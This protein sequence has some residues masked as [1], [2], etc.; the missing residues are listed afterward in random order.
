MTGQAK[1]DYQ[2]EYMRRRRSNNPRAPKVRPK[3]IRFRILQRDGFRCQYCGRTA[4]DDVR[5]EIDHIRPRCEGGTDDM[6]NLITACVEWN[7]SKGGK[8]LDYDAEQSLM[9]RTEQPVIPVAPAHNLVRPEGVS[10]NQWAYIKM[11]AG[12]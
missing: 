9:S 8:A 10:N 4:A 2:R 3:P 7:R 1:T 12:Q 5:L 6:T 11:R